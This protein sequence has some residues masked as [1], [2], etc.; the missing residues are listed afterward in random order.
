MAKKNFYAVKK[1]LVPGI[2]KTWE[3][4]QRNVKGFPGAEYKGFVTEAEAREY[5]TD[6]VPECSESEASAY[7]DGSFCVQ[8]GEYAYGVVLFCNGEELHF[9]EKFSDPDMAQMRNV[10]GEIEGAKK[11]MQFCR[12]NGIRS[13]DLYYDYEGIE[14]WCSG[15]WQ[16]KK[17][18]TKE[19]KAFYDGIQ[20]SVAV[21]FKKV[22]AH[23]GVTYNEMADALAKQAL[24]ILKK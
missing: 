20:G 10:A 21:H 2:Y 7:V 6:A 4:C 24:G 12:E 18:G 16:A 15:E 9:C 14:K 22:A 11:A 19:Y 13:L 23:T 8:T 1:G 5:L 17:A 3:E